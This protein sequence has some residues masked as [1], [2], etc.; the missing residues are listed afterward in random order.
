MLGA[1][2]VGAVCRPDKAA[3]TTTVYVNSVC[4]RA[5]CAADRLVINGPASDHSFT[6]CT[7]LLFLPARRFHCRVSILRSVVVAGASIMADRGRR[8]L[9]AERVR[10]RVAGHFAKKA[11][12]CVAVRAPGIDGGGGAGQGSITCRGVRRRRRWPFVPA[13]D[14]C[15]STAPG[16]LSLHRFSRQRRR[17]AMTRRAPPGDY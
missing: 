15:C 1:T 12:L 3:P 4:Q 14:R 17:R 6:L 7:A 2:S 9:S 16:V 13:A 10:G 5:L 8:R 11:L